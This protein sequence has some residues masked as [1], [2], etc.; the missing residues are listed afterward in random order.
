[1]TP[2]APMPR[3]SC[4]SA[5][6]SVLAWL[7]IVALP[8]A[9]LSF[10]LDGAGESWQ[11]LPTGLRC[12]DRLELAWT[13]RV[14]AEGWIDLL[15]EGSDHR[16][17]VSAAAQLVQANRGAWTLPMHVGAWAGQAGPL[18][19]DAVAGLV[20][21]GLRWRPLAGE[22]TLHAVV[23]IA[24]GPA[25]AP[26]LRLRWPPLVQGP[27]W[28][29][30]HF[31]LPGA[32]P[33]ATLL[34]DRGEGRPV[35]CFMQQPG[36]VVA[37]AW[38]PEGEAFHT[39]R[40][41]ADELGGREW[42]IIHESASG[43]WT[44]P[45]FPVPPP[46]IA[47]QGI[48]LDGTT[49]RSRP[50]DDR[51]TLH[52]PGAEPMLV[53]IGISG[54]ESGCERLAP[55]LSWQAA[56]T[57]WR[58]PR[59]VGHAAAAALDQELTRSW[60]QVDLLPQALFEERGALRFGLSPWHVDQGGPWNCVE[61]A[62]AHD[63]PLADL[64]KHARAVI[65][66]SRA[67]PGLAQWVV[68]AQAAAN[69]PPSLSR[70]HGWLKELRS[71]IARTDGRPLL[72][73]HPQV[74]PW[75]RGDREPWFD[76]ERDAQGWR[77]LRPG[78]VLNQQE[79]ASTSSRQATAGERSLHLR[80]PAS[81]AH[82]VCW[83]ALSCPVDSGLYDLDRLEF[84]ALLRGNGLV[85]LIVHVTDSEH[86][87]YQQDIGT[88]R[89]GRHWRT[90]GVDFDDAADWRPVGHD[91]PWDGSQRRRIRELGITAWHWRPA[92]ERM[93][94]TELH[95]DRF[96]RREWPRQTAP[97]LTIAVHELD[98]GHVD[99]TA[100]PAY[101]PFGAH[102]A[103]SVAAKNPYDPDEADVVAELIAPDG[104][105]IV[106]PAYW[107]QVYRCDLAGDRENLRATGVD[108]WRFRYSPRQEGA[109]RWRIRAKIRFQDRWLEATSPWSELVVGP[110]R[111]GKILPVRQSTDP[112]FWE[113]VDGKFFYPIGIN[114]RS[115]GDER[116]DALLADAGS[117]IRNH[118][119][120][121]QG[122]AA[123][124]RWFDRLQEHGM[125]Y[126]RVWMCPWWCGLEWDRSW[127]GYGGL[128]WYHQGNAA[129]LDRLVAM[130][131]ERGIHLQIELQNHGQ[132]A[133]KIDSDWNRPDGSSP[134]RR[135]GQ[136]H[137]LVDRPE[138]FF[139]SEACWQ[140]LAKRHRYVL[141]RWGCEPAIMAWVLSS[142]LEFTGSWYRNVYL[143][144][145]PDA[146]ANDPA[147]QAWIDRNLSWWRQH[148]PDRPV[149]IHFSHPWVAA[150][151]WRE[152]RL[153]FSNSNVYSGFQTDMNQLGGSN[154]GLA[155]AFKM[156]LD[157]YFPPW[158]LGRPAM[159][160]EWG[161]HWA[162]RSSDKLAA[163]LRVG[164]WL[165][166]V[167][168]YGGNVGFWWWLWL[169][170]TES[171]PAYGAIA[172]FMCEEDPRGQERRSFR[173]PQRGPGSA[174]VFGSLGRS[175]HR[176]YA[177]LRGL[178]KDAHRRDDRDAGSFAVPTAWPGRTWRCRRYD[179]G[180]G[181]L[182]AE[183]ELVADAQGELLISLGALA[184]DAAFKLDLVGPVP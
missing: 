166:A 148:D 28:S 71:F 143:A 122:L 118:E 95:L 1:M 110:P 96:L 10:Q 27:H 64:A 152:C 14:P 169:D 160:G 67:A 144:G 87:W 125:N 43:T 146:E 183:Q 104:R 162:E 133:T 83:A 161:G 165:Q 76:F 6:L 156:Y 70:W 168:P 17:F 119:Y 175:S 115:P 39:A 34:L 78:L 45:A 113:T 164:T 58:G 114:L 127:D 167:L 88:V 158:Q 153:G 141:A 135:D 98:G 173:P 59:L 121:A 85:T 77:E 48:A 103:L 150:R 94:P 4:R 21:I 74:R 92:P 86:R 19:A 123:Y 182:V 171:W 155:T 7:A 154:A 142:E 184:P 82:Q 128:G 181:T 134:Y 25:A 80:L 117:S 157:E 22:S 40:L 84:D 93:L 124:V 100:H 149:S 54:Q 2:F 44:S 66:R 112:R 23:T 26:V 65:A 159:L 68:G 57:G 30:L 137:G 61:E 9:D 111:A 180:S 126:A 51:A 52:V 60:P 108:R 163:E 32:D 13:A 179:C 62:F 5:T 53:H 132:T 129:R 178:D 79:P 120:E 24:P 16:H 38:R 99:G 55:L 42:R 172:E 170:A 56:W 41:R 72:V 46:A 63:A 89:A 69:D 15:L 116:Q 105:E 106:H 29:E 138:E 12:G 49:P 136:G 177:W 35:P 33:D 151:I 97:E 36:R 81:D 20:R 73:E 75:L 37:G 139:T 147:T 47:A 90:L 102:F 131:D 174:F 91:R 11:G 109:W 176:F 18:D 130:A 3:S 107:E 140:Q 31:D 50:A 101:L 8:A 145:S